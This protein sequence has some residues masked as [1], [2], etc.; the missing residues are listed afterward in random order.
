M[1]RSSVADQQDTVRLGSS[2][3]RTVAASGM[4]TRI[5]SRFV[6]GMLVSKGRVHGSQQAG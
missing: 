4:P 3:P 6:T 1:V 2:Q 5:T